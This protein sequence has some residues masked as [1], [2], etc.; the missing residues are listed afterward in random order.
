[1]LT[2]YS[3]KRPFTIFVAVVIVAVFGFVSVYRM[4]PELFPNIDTPYAVVMTTYPGASAEEVE[5]QI[6][7]P[8]EEQLATLSNLDNITSTSSDNYSAITLAF[9][10][11]VNMDSISVDIR[12]KIDQITDLPESA[13]KPLVMKINMDMMPV[14]VAAISLEGQSAS[15]VSEYVRENMKNKLEGTE[16]VA[17]V[18][19]IGM[20]D[21]GVQIVL[22]QDD[23]D[24]INR[25]VSSAIASKFSSGERDIKKGIR[26]AKKGSSQ[27]EDAKEE[28]K[29]TTNDASDQITTAIKQMKSKLEEAEE[30]Y[31]LL[32]QIPEEYRTEEQEEQIA[33][34]ETTIDALKEG[35]E[36]LYAQRDSAIFNIGT[37]YSDITVSQSS[38]DAVVNQ[39][40]SSLSEVESQKKAAIDS[41]DMTGV[42]TMENISA[43]LSA[44]NFSMPAGYV[45][46]GDAKI[47]VSVG[48]KIKDTKELKNLIL[49][50]MGIDG[51][52]PVRLK[53]IGTISSVDNSSDSYAKVNGQNGILLTFSKQSNYPAATVANNIN[54]TFE[55]LEKDNENLNVVA[56]FDQGQYINTVIKS[57][58]IDL[59]LGALFAV[60][61]LMFF[62]RDIRPTAIT[63]I[64]IPVSV[65]FAIALMYFTGISLNII[66][67][68]GL[69]IGVGMLVDNSI[70]VIENIYRL[71]SMGYT[72]VQAA[73]SG[74][75]QVAG[76]ITASTLT[77]ICVF[78]PI[79]FVDGM[80]KQIFKDLALTV[81]YS[82]MASLI[83]AVTFVPAV[84]KGVLVRKTGKT[85]LGQKGR[86]VSMYKRMAA[87][88]LLH[89]KRVLAG[90]LV[91]LLASNVLL[92]MKG[93]EFMP[94]MESTEISATITMPE[95]ST[96]EDT[97]RINDKI[98]SEIRKNEAVDYVGVMLSSSM[99]SMYG[100]SSGEE[101]ASQTMMYIVLKENMAK[102]NSKVSK[103]F[104]ELVKK[105]GCE[106]ELSAAMDMSSM[107]GEEGVSMN[108]YSDDLD[109]LR[110]T[111]K[112][113]EDSMRQ[114]K[115]LKEVSDIG[116]VSTDELRIVVNKNAAMEKGLTVAQVYQQV[117]SKLA[118]D[119]SATKL[120][121]KGGKT[122][123]VNISNSGDEGIAKADLMDLKL[124]AT[125]QDGTS[126]KV[127][128]SSIANIKK[129]ASLNQIDHD[130]QKRN[131]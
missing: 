2:K 105:N 56:M 30:G 79:I 112:N 113:V 93:F 1:M 40:Q 18:S 100:M 34:L 11:K 48:D 38:L 131:L 96:L 20:I 3:V 119:S 90:A 35:I 89:K 44:Q 9:T 50:D 25:K 106:T 26:E 70:V 27:I 57:V 108:L 83:I 42:I 73:V 62:L 13:S 130:D 103:E 104:E 77:T 110:R 124:T 23:I 115:A 109:S 41:A 84:S 87:W 16:G 63:A 120:T 15:E 49:F 4:T 51:V 69:A 98:S 21:E 29:N 65:I 33:I 74:A 17:S 122:V 95:G 99:D 61:V 102:E 71:R 72:A 6:T 22:S 116:D 123:D 129:D 121:D 128:L 66:S 114:M 39:L 14:E 80:T 127:S 68:S 12:D 59:L 76:A 81:T 43:V 28:M 24:E 125:K 19:Y 31:K 64:S 53:D 55:K 118:K 111:A 5:V 94:E 67:M 58:F 10:D 47:L 52:D 45:T 86:V 60:F 107:I 7:D 36:D 101:D 8:L 54:S 91:L 82:L 88:S 126:K 75:G 78:V 92:L 37:T 117:S 32:S 97:I 46:D 85:V